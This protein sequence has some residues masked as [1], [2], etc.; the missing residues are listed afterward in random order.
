MEFHRGPD[1]QRGLASQEPT[2]WPLR[3]AWPS[4]VEL[5]N[6]KAS[7]RLGEVLPAA[8]LQHPLC[9]LKLAI[10]LELSF[11][12]SGTGLPAGAILWTGTDSE[13]RC[14]RC[15]LGASRISLP[16]HMPWQVKDGLGTAE[17]SQPRPLSPN[18][19]TRCWLR[20][21]TR[22]SC[23]ASKDAFGRLNPPCVTAAPPIRL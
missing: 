12:F 5:A 4:A 9:C 22:C 20:R 8:R 18:L 13:E 6:A 1:V 21:T 2:E 3:K 16:F 11:G 19:E 15:R 17:L 23:L 10:D 7:A 14:D